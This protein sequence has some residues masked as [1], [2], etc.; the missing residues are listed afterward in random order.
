VN[1]YQKLIEVRKA[2]PYLQKEATGSQYKYVSTSQV[3]A[4]LK[5]KMDELQLLLIPRVINHKVSESTVQYYSLDPDKRETEHVTKRTTT[6]FTEL[7]MTMTWI[8]AE[9]PEETIECPWYGQGVDIAGEKGVG[10]A[11]TYSEKYFMLKFF[12]IPTDKDDPDSFQE[13]HGDKPEAE[14]VVTTKKVGTKDTK[15]KQTPTTTEIKPIKWPVF[16]AEMSKLGYDEKQVHAFAK[17]ESLKEWNKVMLDELYRDIK[18]LV[19]KNQ[20][21]EG[22]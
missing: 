7:E 13:K 10:K 12:N 17:V 3:L 9:N 21:L 8:N 16:W 2:T 11:L 22:K 19:N 1:I 5:A 6:Y 14:K 4:S 20:N 18:A 15:Q